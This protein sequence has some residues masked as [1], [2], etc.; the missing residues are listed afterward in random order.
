MTKKVKKQKLAKAIGQLALSEDWRGQRRDALRKSMLAATKAGDQQA[1]RSFSYELAREDVISVRK[2]ASAAL[3]RAGLSDQDQP[4]AILQA[5][6]LAIR[7]AQRRPDRNAGAS[8][9]AIL[10]SAYGGDYAAEHLDESETWLENQRLKAVEE[11]L[12]KASSPQEREAWAYRL[13]RERLKAGH[14]RG[15]I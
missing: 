2:E 5:S 7:N 1:A 11:G 4:R 12:R 3:A 9:R 13:T 14:R 15:E 10:Q 6:A 8:Q